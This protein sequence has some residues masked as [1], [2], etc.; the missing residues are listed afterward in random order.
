M[1]NIVNSDN[2]TERDHIQVP[3]RILFTT[4]MSFS[5]SL[6]HIWYMLK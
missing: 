3:K 5:S 1:I 4:F 2:S 6:I